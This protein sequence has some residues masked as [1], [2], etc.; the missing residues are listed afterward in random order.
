MSYPSEYFSAFVKKDSDELY[1]LE[2]LLEG[3][4]CAGCIQKI[5]S[6][7]KRNPDIV[8]A[9][10]NFS[11][12]R[13]KLVWKGS[14][15]LADKI[16]ND[17][18]NIGYKVSVYNAQAVNK[19]YEKE[20]RFL[21]LCTGVAGFAAG[22]IM[23]MS[24][25]LWTT[26]ANVMGIAT[27]DFLHWISA[28]IAIPAIAFSGRPFFYSALKVLKSGR[29]NMDVPISLALLLATSMSLFQLMHHAE[30]AY[31]DSAVMLMFFLLVGRYLDF[32]ARARARG[33]AGDLLAL[34]AGT[35]S[36]I[37]DN[38][39]R[40]IAISELAEGMI[41]QVGLG[42]RIPADGMVLAGSSEIDMSLITGETMLVPASV[43][44]H[45]YSGSLN[46]S[47][48]LRIQVIRKADDSFLADIIRLM[49][50]AEQSQSAYVRL[51]DRVARLYTPV[52]HILAA[53]SFILWYGFWGATWYQAL[54]VSVT[55][56]IITCPCALALAVPVVQV[57][58]I[59]HLMKKGIMIKAG[60][61]LE[62][63]AKIDCIFFDKTG[64]LT[65]G[66]PALF[67]KDQI[68][69]Q[70]I[71]LAAS[72]ATH[73]R[74]PLSRALV[75]EYQKDLLDLA[76]EEI[77]GRGLQSAYNGQTVRLGSRSWCG[78]QQ[79]E[80][81]DQYLELWLDK[82]IDTKTRFTFFDPLREDAKPV[83]K[84]MSDYGLEM[85]LL[86]GDREAAVRNVA[87]ELGITNWRANMT[88]AEK[89]S[90]MENCRM[91]GKK[92]L[93][94]GDGL[95]DAPVLTAADISMS[96]STAIDVSQ[97]A[98]DI[99]FTGE[100]LRAV[101][102]AYKTALLSQKLVKQNFMLSIAYNLI[103]VPLAFTGHVNPLVAAI[104]MSSSS[105][106]VVL[107]SFRLASQK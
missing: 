99:V 19:E 68:S 14:V 85:F 1:S 54:L 32:R 8:D 59:G 48:S 87:E 70:D 35:A 20:N 40:I 17:I 66:R 96:P 60:D 37:E 71:R 90:Q 83:I 56:L 51:A 50:K 93:M 91:Q 3:I 82:G 77:I 64:T 100:R 38:K 84:N 72:M 21:L 29:T 62:R 105:L 104:A 18:I 16:A 63:L 69:E 28:L 11:T 7:A 103:A 4:N 92:V 80:S 25:A 102:V 101:T 22:N 10:L 43:G 57:L 47:S 95:N 97:N 27:R 107:N 31:F 26:Q 42:E 41:V 9:R 23:L 88:P 78:D 33:A 15:D 76:V 75:N 73:S 45:V 52:V 13:L 106:F 61:A 30:D 86:S 53:A 81:N 55:V 58:A 79:F 44:D 67:N 65:L 39:Q 24:F 89:F 12:K 6:C 98:A 94:V 46:N 34:M 49:E 5:E 36:V 74:H 2:L